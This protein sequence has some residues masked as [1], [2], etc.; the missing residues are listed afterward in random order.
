M[1]RCPPFKFRCSLSAEQL[2][3][4]I[5]SILRRGGVCETPLGLC[6]ETEKT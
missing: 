2:R 4:K 6:N 3:S 1:D 5:Q